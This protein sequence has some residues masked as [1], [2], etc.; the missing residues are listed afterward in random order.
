MVQTSLKPGSPFNYPSGHKRPW[1]TKL[2]S[3][4]YQDALA[5]GSSLARRQYS[6]SRVPKMN[7]PAMSEDIVPGFAQPEELL[8]PL[9]P[10]SPPRSPPVRLFLFQSW[11]NFV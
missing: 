11:D 1:P 10:R 8:R 6:D 3:A 9:L 4:S 2:S 7:V 5:G